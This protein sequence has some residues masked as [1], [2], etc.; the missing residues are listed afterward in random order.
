MSRGCIA[1]SN[2]IKYDFRSDCTT[3]NKPNGKTQLIGVFSAIAVS[4][5]A[6]QV[7]KLVLTTRVTH[8][9]KSK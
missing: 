1:L 9:L 6:K 3:V 4:T 7:F 2:R 8:P 5:I